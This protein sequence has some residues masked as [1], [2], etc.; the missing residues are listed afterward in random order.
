M[1]KTYKIFFCGK[2]SSQKMTV[3]SN[4]S[5]G[6]ELVCGEC[7][8]THIKAQRVTCTVDGFNVEIDEP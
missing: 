3:R 8:T 4:D 7:G 5:G 1:E 2:C 6:S